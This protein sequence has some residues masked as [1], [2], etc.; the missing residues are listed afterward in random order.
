MAK[1]GK[2]IPL[3][4]LCAV[5]QKLLP[6]SPYDP[7]SIGG[8]LYITYREC[9]EHPGAMVLHP[10]ATQPVELEPPPRA[11]QAPPSARGEKRS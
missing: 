6:P 5:C 9:P 7:V 8:V 2:T 10:D 4:P 3:G 1:D 11:F